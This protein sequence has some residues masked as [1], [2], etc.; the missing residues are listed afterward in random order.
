MKTLATIVLAVFALLLAAALF[1][2]FA[3]D[4]PAQA[5]RID[6]LVVEH[7]Y[8]GPIE[9]TGTLSAWRYDGS[10]MLLEYAPDGDGI[11]RNGF[12]GPEIGSCDP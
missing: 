9:R 2:A 6:V 12:D 1:A 8:T 3:A 4:A 10:A 5:A 11:Y 7:A